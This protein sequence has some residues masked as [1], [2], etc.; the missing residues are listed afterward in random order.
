MYIPQ[1]SLFYD[2]HTMPSCPDV[3]HDFDVDQFADRIQRCG[4][5]YITFHARMP[6]AV[7]CGRF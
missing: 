5:D 1:W 7:S 4:V 2:N 3:G 6:M